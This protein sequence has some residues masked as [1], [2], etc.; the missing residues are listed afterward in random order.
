MTEATAEVTAVEVENATE[1]T[2][3][4]RGRPRPQETIERDEQV[5]ATIAGSGAGLTRE[6][7]AA[8]TGLSSKL[9]YMSLYR[10]RTAGRIARRYEDGRHV[11][12]ATA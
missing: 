12:A 10:L 6:E 8:N 9:V 3:R 2:R 5:H 7:I 4:R 11:W 1:A